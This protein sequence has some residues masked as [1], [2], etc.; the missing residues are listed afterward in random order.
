M[1]ARRSRLARG[2]RWLCAGALALFLVAELVGRTLLGLGTPPLYEADAGFEY[3]MLPNQ[4]VQRFGNHIMVNRWG[5]RSI[6]FENHKTHP[7]ELRVMVF[8]DSVVNGG[9][10]ID[11][12]ELGTTLLRTALQQ[13][14]SRPVNVGN[15][16]TGSWGPGNWLAYA[17]RFGFF[18]ADVV[19]LVLGSGDHADNPTFAPLGADHPTQAPALALQ[20]AMQRYLPRYL[21]RYLPQQLRA[22]SAEPSV[23]PMDKLAAE[24]SARGLGDLQAFLMKASAEGRRVMVLHHPDRNETASGQY[25]E[26]HSQIR[27]LVQAL[28]LPFIELRTPYLS[29]GTEVYRDDIH[30]SAQGQRVMAHALFN[31][32]LQTLTTPNPEPTTVAAG[33]RS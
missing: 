31:A 7:D 26:G 13:R 33:A 11:Q 6:D 29:A 25:L 1:N 32:V 9:S 15:I 17:E 14:L 3:R 21:A 4:D 22:W 2:A 5:M 30:H 23:T 12:S 8:G 19:L 27:S 16:S 20:E 18:D 28:E 24:A 10:Q